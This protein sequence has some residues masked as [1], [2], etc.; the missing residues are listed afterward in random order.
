ML[1]KCPTF[2]KEEQKNML[3]WL[4]WL[5]AYNVRVKNII[6]VLANYPEEEKK[7]EIAKEDEL[8]KEERK[9]VLI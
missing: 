9:I 5:I 8:I 3:I 6:I 7:A 4:S 2:L 1:T